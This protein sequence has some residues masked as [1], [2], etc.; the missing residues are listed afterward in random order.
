MFLPEMGTYHEKT[1]DKPRGTEQDIQT[2]SQG[3]GTL[4]RQGKDM[5]QSC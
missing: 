1:P 2:Q 5:E 3:T 4:T